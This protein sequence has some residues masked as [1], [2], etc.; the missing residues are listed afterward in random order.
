[1]NAYWIDKL[2]EEIMSEVSMQTW[3]K[4]DEFYCRKENMGDLSSTQRGILKSMA[5]G[6]LMPLSEKQSKALYNVFLKDEDH[7]VIN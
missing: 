7:G 4:V 1:M 3:S 5:S 6:R 2:S